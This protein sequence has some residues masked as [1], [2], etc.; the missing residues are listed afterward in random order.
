MAAITSKGKAWELSHSIWMLWALLT[1]GT[2]NYISFFYTSYKVKQ[3][4]WFIAGI[5]YAILFILFMAASELPSEHW[6]YGTTLAVYFIGWIVSIIH[7][8]KMRT[9]YLLRLEAQLLSGQKEIEIKSLKRKI[10]QEYG[11][12]SLLQTAE[13]ASS[14]NVI[15]QE[16][17][18]TVQQV[19]E[20]TIK[21]NQIDIEFIDINTANEDKIANVPGI[22]SL[23]AKKVVSVRD[24]VGGFNSFEHFVEALSIKPH[25]VEKIKPHL[26]FPEEVIPKQTKKPEGRIVDF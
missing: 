20:K 13:I 19:E 18:E 8:F 5:V 16:N 10:A 21:K 7:V 3:K 4:K 1:F 23:F 22:G 6:L 15:K 17:I 25:L 11:Q 24:E 12:T 2:L 9:E 26:S 14:Q